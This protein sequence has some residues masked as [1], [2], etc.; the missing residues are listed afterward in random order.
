MYN[1]QLTEEQAQLVARACEFYARIRIGQFNE[2]VW[3]CLDHSLPTEDYCSRRDL[4]E[5]A[6]LQARSSI[7]PDLH[8]MG[9][10]YGIGKFE[11]ADKSYDVYQV[12]RKAMGD[13]RDPYSHYQLPVC[14]KIG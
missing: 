14:T 3:E 13:R 6:L 4:A 12:L 10:S 9:H 8:G 11:D 5:I 7:F 2:I 1:L